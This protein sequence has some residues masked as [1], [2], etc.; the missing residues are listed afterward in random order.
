M[1][2]TG[3]RGLHKEVSDHSA[4]NFHVVEH[5]SCHFSNNSGF[6]CMKKLQCCQ[7]GNCVTRFR[8]LSDHISGF[9]KNKK[10]NSDKFSNLVRMSE[11]SQKNIQIYEIIIQRESSLSLSMSLTVTL[12]LCGTAAL[13]RLCCGV[14]KYVITWALL[15]FAISLNQ[16]IL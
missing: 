8:D 7:I 11:K 1:A 3:A 10:K 14:C 6:S 9:I 16:G 13:T 2:S 15:S 12:W 5:F 4:Q